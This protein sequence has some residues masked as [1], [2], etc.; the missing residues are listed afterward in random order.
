MDEQTK[1]KTERIDASFCQK[2]DIRIDNQ[3]KKIEYNFTRNQDKD[4]SD[5]SRNV[6]QAN[7]KK[8]VTTHCT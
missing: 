6:H 3:T 7:V 5:M 8:K 1:E 2:G 4:N